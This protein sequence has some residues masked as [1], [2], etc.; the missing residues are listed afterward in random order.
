MKKCKFLTTVALH[1][2]FKIFDTCDVCNCSKVKNTHKPTYH[3][4][5]KRTLFIPELPNGNYSEERLI[6]YN[7]ILRRNS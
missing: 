4:Q 1:I 2:L 6:I 7:K 5:S 3:I